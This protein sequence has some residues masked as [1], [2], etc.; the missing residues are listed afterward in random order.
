MLL[1]PTN[2]HLPGN[3]RKDQ[4]GFV[5]V[6]AA[7]GFAA[8]L[9]AAGLSV[10]LGRVYIARNEVQAFADSAALAAG[11]QLNGTSSGIAAADP[12]VQNTPNKWNH[13]TQSVSY[14][15]VQFA[16]P[17]AANGNQ[18]DAASWTAAPASGKVIAGADVP[19]MLARAIGAQS[20]MHAARWQP[21]DN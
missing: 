16:L 6:A 21:A 2:Q 7:V 19:I 17:S 12:A 20:T 1:K 10:D 9:G 13:G 5:L 14:P 18:P 4:K 15:T 3:V 11:L 8:V